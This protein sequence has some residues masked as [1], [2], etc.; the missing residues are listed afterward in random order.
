MGGETATWHASLNPENFLA[1]MT[2]PKQHSEK[3]MRRE[4]VACLAR[5]A[6]NFSTTK[7]PQPRLGSGGFWR[8][9]S[10]GLGCYYLQSIPYRTADNNPTDQPLIPSG[11]HGELMLLLLSA[12]HSHRNRDTEL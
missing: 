10:N 4:N 11:A 12:T 8:N 6:D 2:A 9:R 1:M 3:N 7:S 5:T